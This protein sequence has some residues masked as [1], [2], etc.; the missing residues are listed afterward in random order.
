MGIAMTKSK[1]RIFTPSKNYTSKLREWLKSN[2]WVKLGN[3]VEIPIQT[4]ILGT[5]TEIKDG[6][7][8]AGELKIKGGENVVIGKY[9]ALADCVHIITTNHVLSRPDIQGRFFGNSDSYKGPVY[10]GNN[11]WLGDNVIVLPGVTIGDGAVVGAGS[12]VTKDVPPF[13]VVAG[14]PAKIIKYRF[15]KKI[16]LA[17]YKIGWWHW[18]E[19][20]K[21]ANASFLRASLNKHN[22]K[23]WIN[24][25]DFGQEL[26]RVEIIFA[27]DKTGRM[28]LDGW[29]ILEGKT[30]WMEKDAAGWVWKVNDP[31]RYQTV[32][33]YGYAY[34]KPHRLTLWIN[35]RRV[36][37]ANIQESWEIIKFPARYLVK[38]V[39]YGRVT[40]DSHGYQPAKIEVKSSDERRLYARFEWLRLI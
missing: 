33:L 3:R 5:P 22:W 19:K 11:A 23:N 20:T 24:S 30:R 28:L 6:A 2:P 40:T 36:G 7:L 32:E 8:I 29:G 39:N 21:L 38:G 9:S 12:V 35:G 18:E 10:I 1:Y 4:K 37:K 31:G 26:E 17:L 16:C 34:A 13:A 25:L 14:V 15:P 27:K